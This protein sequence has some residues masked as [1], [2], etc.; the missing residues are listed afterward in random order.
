M[1]LRWDLQLVLPKAH[2]SA[3]RLVPHL[4]PPKVEQLAPREVFLSV[5]VRAA[6]SVDLWDLVLAASK[7]H[8]SV[9]RLAPQ[10]VPLT[11]AQWVP[12]E[13]CRLVLLRAVRSAPRWACLRVRS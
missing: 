4:A 5:A 8:Q 2:Q 3:V 12:R 13:A 9:P 7:A 6:H 11:V 1:A 10:L